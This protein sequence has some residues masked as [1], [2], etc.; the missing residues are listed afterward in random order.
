M[1]PRGGIFRAGLGGVPGTFFQALAAFGPG[2][3]GPEEGEDFGVVESDFEEGGEGG[4]GAADDGDVDFADAG[5]RSYV[6]CTRL[7]IIS[8]RKTYMAMY[9]IF[10][11]QV[12]SVV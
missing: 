9:R 10:S 5:E 7:R 3:A 12:I 11:V 6:S 8:G 4:H 1:K 2:A